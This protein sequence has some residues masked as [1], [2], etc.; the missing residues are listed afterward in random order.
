[1]AMRL[2]AYIRVSTEAQAD[3]GAGLEA[4]LESCERYAERNG[5]TIHQVFKD[6]G[7]SGS[8]KIEDRLGLMS[9]INELKKDDVLLVAKRDRLAR[10]TYV[11]A[12]IKR[13]IESKKARIISAAGEG[14]DQNDPASKMLTGIVDVF[15]EYERDMIRARTKAALQAMKRDGKRVGHI[16]F[17]FRL[18]QDGVYLEESPEEQDILRQMR[19]LR[20]E[21]LSIREIANSLNERNAFNR[22]QAKWNHGS[23]HRIMKMAA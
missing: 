19:E 21:G 1:M 8:A 13:T 10:D 3:S 7:I 16:P 15:A 14:T 20:A 9:A 6:E 22:G 12:V 17:G 11:I 23:V 18:A 4:Q 2:L 5:L